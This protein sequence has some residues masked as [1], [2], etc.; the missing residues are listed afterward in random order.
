MISKLENGLTI[1]EDDWDAAGTIEAELLQSLRAELPQSKN[2]SVVLTIRNDTGDL[3]GGL[4]SST[5][6]GWMLIKTLWVSDRERN[7]GFGRVLMARAEIKA[8]AMGCHAAWLDTS[9]PA[10]HRFYTRLGY[11]TFGQLQNAPGR[12]P[13]SHRRWFMRKELT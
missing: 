5:S 7:K 9:S 3:I 2:L 12:N 1:V 6:Y 13:P 11:Q 8:Q 4:T 10:A